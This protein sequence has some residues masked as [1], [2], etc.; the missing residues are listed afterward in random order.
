MRHLD[1]P[2]R[3]RR[4]LESVEL[5]LVAERLAL[6]GLLE[7]RQRLFEARLALPVRNV[8]HIVRAR[9]AAAPDAEV[10]AAAAEM[11]DR[12]HLFRDPQRVRQRQHGDGS[13]DPDAPRAG[14]QEAG[15]CDR[16]RL[17]GPRG[18]EVDLAQ[19]DAVQSPRLGGVGQ[20]ERLLESRRL[21]RLAAALLDEDPEVHAAQWPGVLRARN[22][23]N[24]SRGCAEVSQVA[25]AVSS[26]S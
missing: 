25:R 16:R 14:G 8:E 17:H 13:P 26:L 22:S 24:P 2:R 12:R 7:D 23:L 21:A 18:I 4:V 9:R 19:P 5:A 15:Q 6:P 1:R 3:H 11:I 20:L 10:E